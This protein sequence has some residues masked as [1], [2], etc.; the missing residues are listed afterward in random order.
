MKKNIAVQLYSLR[1]RV[2]NDLPA[3]LKRVAD[4]GF[5]GVEFAGFYD[6]P[7][8]K[9]KEILSDLGLKSAASHT[10]LE[11][12]QN[13]LVQTLEYN[14]EIGT[15]LMVV[16]HFYPFHGR[17]SYEQMGDWCA[18]WA[19]EAKKYGMGFAYHNHAVEIET[20]F[21]GKR[22]IDIILSASKDI[23]FQA[24]VYWLK[25]V[26]LNPAEFLKDY[27]GRLPVIHLKDMKDEKSKEMTEVGTGIVDIKSIV[28]NCALYGTKWLTVEQDTIKGDEFAS[29]KL[30]LENIRKLT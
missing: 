5:D 30:S 22:G 4:M 14:A 27:I 1:D 3:L 12:F 18:K 13:E 10:G 20:S 29:I 21:F 25:Y 23:Q 15:E 28:K 7:A 2:N 16:P 9:L 19:E 11:L 8:K 17:Q 6:V 24:D 26:G